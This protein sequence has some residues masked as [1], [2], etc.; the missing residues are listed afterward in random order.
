MLDPTT[1]PIAI[2]VLPFILAIK[3]TINSGVE[4]PK[5]TIVSPITILDILYFLASEAD[6]STKKSAPFI[7]KTKPKIKSK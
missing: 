2:S 4:V 6:P 5:A 1:L 7:N 3:L